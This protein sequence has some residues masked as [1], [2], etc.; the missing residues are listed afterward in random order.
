MRIKLDVVPGRIGRTG[1]LPVALGRFELGCTEY[2]GLGHDAMRGAVE[3]VEPAAHAAW[4]AAEAADA[5]S[6]GAEDERALAEEPDRPG[7]PGW[8]RFAPDP[9]GARA[10]GWPWDPP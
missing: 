4:L 7:D 1:F 9:A 10:W 6:V 2:C 8:P 5:R 3:V